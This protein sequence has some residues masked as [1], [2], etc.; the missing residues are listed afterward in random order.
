MSKK[1]VR[2]L[3]KKATQLKKL[4]KIDEAINKLEEAYAIGSYS[5]PSEVTNSVNDE[6]LDNYITTEDLVRKAKYL[7]ESGKFKEALIYLNE[8]MENTSSRANKSVWEIFDLSKLYNHRAI[9]LKKEKNFKEEFLDRIR[10]YCL[11]GVATRLSM[12]PKPTGDTGDELFR[13]KFSNYKNDVKRIQNI[14]IS[15]T[16]PKKLLKFIKDNSANINE[17]IDYNIIAAFMLKMIMFDTD[18]DQSLL[19]LKKLIK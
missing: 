11:D 2:Y 1:N 18:T 17:K 14:L 9:I 3:L 5:Y 15:N 4:K 13:L 7:Q 10:S 6:D 16:N 8:L 12:P 19:E